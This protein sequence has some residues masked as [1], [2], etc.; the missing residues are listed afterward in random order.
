MTDPD[1]GAS[2]TP[3]EDSYFETGG[4]TDIPADTSSAGAAAP[5]GENE[6]AA[7]ANDDPQQ[8]A[9]KPEKMVAL[10]AL[11]EERGRRKD[12][13][14]QNRDLQQQLAE[15]RGRF[16]VI[17]RLQAPRDE[18]P[19]RPPT[20]EEA[21]LTTAEHVAH[22]QRRLEQREASER[23]LGQQNALVSAYRSDAAQFEATTPDFK[24]AYDHLLQSRAQELMALGY[25]DP[26][27]LQQALIADEFAVAQSALARGR[28]PAQ[29]I[30]SLARQRGYAGAPGTGRGA[31]RLDTI[32][33]GQAANKSLSNTG[34]GSGDAEISA[35]AL[36]KMPMDEFE[37]WCTKNPA[38]AKRLMGG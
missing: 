37:A 24:A 8:A 32:A 33:R 26:Q 2:L 23:A 18:T 21:V 25:D 30:Y 28:S 3:A 16:A 36:L 13:D 11:H 7:P 20:V 4:A 1:L 14:R 6:A 38:K 10:A 35:E 31:D 17:E 9:A 34:G 12:T 22:L 29:I 5:A 15:M 27:A 19:Q